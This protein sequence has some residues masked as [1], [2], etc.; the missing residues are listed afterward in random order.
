MSILLFYILFFFARTDLHDSILVVNKDPAV[1]DVSCVK[2]PLC[3]CG[4][5]SN[6]RLAR[7]IEQRSSFVNDKISLYCDTPDF[8]SLSF[9]IPLVM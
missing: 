7:V 8:V 9:M 5:P 2:S 4:N 6:F 3:R 1:T